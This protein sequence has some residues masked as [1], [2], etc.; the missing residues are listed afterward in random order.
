MRVVQL[1]QDLHN[2]SFPGYKVPLSVRGAPNISKA[3][4]ATLGGR[5]GEGFC[6]LGP[7]STSLL[8]GSLRSASAAPPFRMNARSGP[9]HTTR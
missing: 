3:L 4:L 9:A 1:G 7:R 5:K 6:A 8:D 2:A